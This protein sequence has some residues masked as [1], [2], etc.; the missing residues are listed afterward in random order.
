MVTNGNKVV[1]LVM[2]VKLQIVVKLHGQSQMSNF[3][4]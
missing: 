4:C 2:V 3:L 1:W